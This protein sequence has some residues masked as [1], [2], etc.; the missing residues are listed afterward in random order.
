MVRFLKDVERIPGYLV[1]L[2]QGWGSWC[3]LSFLGL[4]SSTLSASPAGSTFAWYLGSR[5]CWILNSAVVRWNCIATKE[6]FPPCETKCYSEDLAGVLSC[7]EQQIQL[8]FL[9]NAMVH[10]KLEIGEWSCGSCFKALQYFDQYYASHYANTHID[11][12]TLIFIP[13]HTLN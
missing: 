3:L 8:S 12:S 9:Q 10:I 6:D 7:A 5:P 2:V 1:T 13:S 4:E 11:K